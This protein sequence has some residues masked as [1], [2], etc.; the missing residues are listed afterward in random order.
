MI[1]TE[2]IIKYLINNGDYATLDLNET[3]IELLSDTELVEESTKAVWTKELVSISGVPEIKMEKCHK[4]VK[5]PFDGHTNIPYPCAYTRTSR[6]WIE[7]KLYYP[8]DISQEIK[9]TILKC[10]LEAAAYSAGIV[11]A[12]I[13]VPEA[14][15]FVIPAAKGVFAAAFTKCVGDEVSK[16]IDYDLTHKS[17]SGDWK[18]L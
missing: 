17:E 4:R 15:P 18:R 8:E 2:P 5:I 6:H 1:T 7:L 9:D 3:S 11:V 13:V 10:G 16:M 14:I 12:S